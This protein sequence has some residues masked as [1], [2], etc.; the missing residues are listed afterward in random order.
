MIKALEMAKGAT[1]APFNL[2]AGL[3]PAT[4]S[5]Q[6]RRSIQL[7]YERSTGCN[8]IILNPLVKEG[9]KISAARAAARQHACA[10]LTTN[11]PHDQNVA[12]AIGTSTSKQHRAGAPIYAYSMGPAG[13][14]LC[15]RA[16]I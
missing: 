12:Q 8:M 14:A 3:E 15:K 13:G 1:G 11:S 9:E 6:G 7:S 5:L 10:L 2:P 4:P 16:S